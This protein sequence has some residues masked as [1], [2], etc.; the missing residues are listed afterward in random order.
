MGEGA[1][2]GSVFKQ[3]NDMTAVLRRMKGKSC[4]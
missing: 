1:G 2:E 3:V 4:V